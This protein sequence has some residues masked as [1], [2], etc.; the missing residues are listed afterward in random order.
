MKSRPPRHTSCVSI[1]QHGLDL[2]Q[3]VARNTRHW[4]TSCRSASE[5]AS[6]APTTTPFDPDPL[7]AWSRIRAAQDNLVLAMRHA[8]TR[9]NDPAAVA[10]MWATDL[11]QPRLGTARDGSRVRPPNCPHG[12]GSRSPAGRPR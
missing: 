3:A 8:L 11:N 9:G 12:R 10:T 2:A 7:S 1:S 6:A 4:C 5:V